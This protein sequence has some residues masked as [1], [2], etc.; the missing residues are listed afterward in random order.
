MCLRFAINAGRS[1]QCTNELCI[2]RT[3]WQNSL[4]PF[5]HMNHPSDYTDSDN[6]WEI[7]VFPMYALAPDSNHVITSSRPS[8]LP[9]LH[10][11]KVGVPETEAFQERMPWANSVGTQEGRL[12]FT[13]VSIYLVTR[14]FKLFRYCCQTHRQNEYHGL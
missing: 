3:Y 11:S 6:V 9:G 10:I 5:L 14:S 4:T 13:I 7:I 1:A 12:V 8:Q 2:S